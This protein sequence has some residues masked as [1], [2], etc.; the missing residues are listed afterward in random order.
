MFKIGNE[1][2]QIYQHVNIV[3]DTKYEKIY[4]WSQQEVNIKI[5][6]LSSCQYISDLEGNLGRI[7]DIK[8]LD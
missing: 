8:L 4:S 2:H 6:E 7:I 1:Y 3:V 5:W